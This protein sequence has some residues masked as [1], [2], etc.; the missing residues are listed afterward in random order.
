MSPPLPM[1]IWNQPSQ[2]LTVSLLSVNVFSLCTQSI[3]PHTYSGAKVLGFQECTWEAREFFGI[4]ILFS[5][6]ALMWMDVFSI[7]SLTE[8]I[9]GIHVS[10]KVNWESVLLLRS[11]HNHFDVW[12]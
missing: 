7:L 10:T 9:R 5:G 1:F 3:I 12:K 4:V 8:K 6:F 2:L 11:L